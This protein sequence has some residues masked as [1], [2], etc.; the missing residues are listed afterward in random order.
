MSLDTHT[1]HDASTLAHPVPLKLL[2]TVFVAL[3]FLTIITYAATWVQLGSFNI[4][5][6]LLIAVIKAGLVA[7]YFMHLRWDSPF[8]GVV[9]IA[10]LIF[11][12][13]FIGIVVLDAKEYR[14]NYSPPVSNTTP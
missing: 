7:M 4:W 5:L 3:A 12:A 6:A 9:L 13:L 10:S 11:V 1:T 8:N 14:L 2:L